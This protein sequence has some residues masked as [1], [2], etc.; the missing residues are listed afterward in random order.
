MFG[1]KNKSGPRR[2]ASVPKRFAAID[3]DSR[4][5]HIVCASRTRNGARIQKL[6]QADIPADID[7][8]DAKALGAFLGKTLKKMRMGIKAVVM[9]VPRGLA[10]LK[11]LQFPPGTAYNE[12]AGM[13]QFQVE[14][15]LPFPLVEAVVDFTVASHYDTE[16]VD[17]HPHVNVL[18]SAV[19]LPVVEH[20]KQIAL[21]AGV[22][23]LRL[24]LRP[25]ATMRCVSECL[26][27]AAAGPLAVIHVTADETEI[28][29]MAGGTLAFSRSAM[30]LSPLG[31]QSD[32]AERARQSRSIAGEIARSLQTYQAAEGGG[33]IDRIL[34]AGGTGIEEGIATS[35][36]K[37]LGV[38][39]ERFSPAEA[40][41]LADDDG[42]ASAF[43]A[44]LGM[45]VG[46]DG[47]A[48][49]FDFIHPKR[50]RVK[51]DVKK[52][53]RRLLVGAAAVMLI[54]SITVGSIWVGQKKAVVDRLRAQ[55]AELKKKRKPLDAQG[56]HLQA[57]RAWDDRG[58]DL[59]GHWAYVSGAAPSCTDVYITSLKMGKEGSDDSLKFVVRAKDDMVIIK[60]S[61]VLRGSRPWAATD[62]DLGY[63]VSTNRVATGEDPFRYLYG[64]TLSVSPP[65]GKK[66]NLS[67]I[68][69]ERRPSDDV[70]SRNETGTGRT[71]TGRTGTDRTRTDRTRTERRR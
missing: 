10:V 6:M 60:F 68:R 23:L 44:A 7:T 30:M 9:S 11:P 2:G 4:R 71:G 51:R 29:V 25:A 12:L 26:G 61:Q 41:V 57:L 53:R 54:A 3:F 14:K 56:K 15:E 63:D 45:A 46:H 50:P 13:V 1:L 37:R 17:D 49:P 24:G 27:E 66:A 65:E 55:A 21:A 16:D 36:Q 22:R 64:T 5:L 59:L 39:C 70:S 48:T 33:N 43:I 35:L 42:R 8:S 20:Y 28:M 19:R 18:V 31:D 38:A 67:G 34:L 47:S 52:I 62:S 32:E 40:L 58:M 69:P